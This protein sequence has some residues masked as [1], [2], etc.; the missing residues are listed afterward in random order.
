MLTG[1]WLKRGAV[2]SVLP[3]EVKGAQGPNLYQNGPSGQLSRSTTK[4]YGGSS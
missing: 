4:C 3:D 1:V 2:Q